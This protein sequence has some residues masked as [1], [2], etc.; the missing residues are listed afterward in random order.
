MAICWLLILVAVLL[1]LCFN[2]ASSPLLSGEE[3]SSSS[4][5]DSSSSSSIFLQNA[6]ISQLQSNI[7][8]SSDLHEIFVHIISSS[9]D[10]Y[11]VFLTEIVLLSITV[12]FSPYFS[13]YLALLLPSSMLEFISFL[14]GDHLR[15][16]LSVASNF[17]LLLYFLSSL[18]YRPFPINQR[19]SKVGGSLPCLVMFY[20][21][22]SGCIFILCPSIL[23]IHT[24]PTF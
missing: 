2:M 16:S 10:L 3:D 8:H 7:A 12:E 5:V 23:P 9:Y 13:G 1:L 17:V 24:V 14:K 11:T 19:Y 21:L 6:R 18:I 22:I 4:A 15:D 20:N